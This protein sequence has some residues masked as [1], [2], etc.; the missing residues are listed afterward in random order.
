[1][2]VS[3]AMTRRSAMTA[4]RRAELFW[5]RV[6]PVGEC[7]EWTGT[8]WNGYGKTTLYGKRM[9]AH[10]AAWILANGDIPEGMV[11]RH[12]CDNRACVALP[13]LELGTA[14]DNQLDSVI[15]NRHACASK[16]HCHNGH[17]L[18]EKGVYMTARGKRQCR[19]CQRDRN[20]RSRLRTALGGAT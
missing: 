14:S 11:V 7:I 19:E 20:R 18:D 8:R 9:N 1:M 10:R 5:A 17:L 3:S 15:R 12:K 16:T 4:E 2:V 13:H 6:V